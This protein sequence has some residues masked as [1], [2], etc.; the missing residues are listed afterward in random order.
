VANKLQD[1]FVFVFVFHHGSGTEESINVPVL[2]GS[3]AVLE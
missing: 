3:N 1:L 2:A